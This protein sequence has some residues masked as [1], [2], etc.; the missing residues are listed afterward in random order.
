MNTL[1][2]Q[3]PTLRLTNK[4]REVG[5]DWFF[6][7]R[8]L[9]YAK[10]VLADLQREEPSHDWHLETRGSQANWHRWQD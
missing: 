7:D 10:S 9:A 4:Y 8:N 2:G 1:N 6:S 5:G 3:F